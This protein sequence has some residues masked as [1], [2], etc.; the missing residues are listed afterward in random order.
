M[1]LYSV[2]CGTWRFLRQ[3]MLAKFIVVVDDDVNVREWGRPL[4]MSAEVTAR[5]ETLWQTL[6]L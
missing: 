2:M 6:G 3:F 5:V 4:S 1:P